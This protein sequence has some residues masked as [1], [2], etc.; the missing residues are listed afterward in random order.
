M[1]APTMAIEGERKRPQQK[2]AGQALVDAQEPGTA[3]NAERRM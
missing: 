1:A 2:V 3:A